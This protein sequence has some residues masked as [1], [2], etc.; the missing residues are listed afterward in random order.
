MSAK[1]CPAI[2][3]NSQAELN[4]Q[5]RITRMLT[6]RYQ[7]DIIDGEFAD[8]KTIT[9][10][11]I[12]KPTDAKLDIHLMV[13]NPL[14]HVNRS[15]SLNP[16]TII[17]QIEAVKTIK[18][19]THIINSINEAGFNSGIAINPETEVSSIARYLPILD[20]VLVMGVDAGFSGQKMKRDVLQKPQQI[21]DIKPPIEIGIDG[22]VNHTTLKAVASSSFDVVNVGSYLFHNPEED[23]LTVYSELLG[24]LL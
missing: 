16:F 7:I 14:D 23:P 15:I 8:N 4:E 10:E 19:I 5:L 1:V 12:P 3:T 21:R 2:L 17:F 6:D 13:N 18:E 24:A 22:G 9:P 11:E 20:H